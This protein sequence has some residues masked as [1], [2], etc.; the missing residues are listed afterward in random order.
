M[1][2]NGKTI[3]KRLEQQGNDRGKVTLYLSK[4]L[5]QEF[6][7]HCGDHSVSIV[8]E[9]LMKDFIRTTRAVDSKKKRSK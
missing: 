9:E 1:T 2:I 5:I 4:K 8:V 7:K 3:L 6:K